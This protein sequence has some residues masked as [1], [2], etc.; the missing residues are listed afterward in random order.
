MAQNYRRKFKK[1][2]GS[3]WYDY[4]MYLDSKLPNIHNI[5]LE[6]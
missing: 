4:K 3:V 5:E 2:Y 1:H 6:C